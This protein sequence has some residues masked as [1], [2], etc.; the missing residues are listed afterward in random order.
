MHLVFVSSLL[1]VKNPASGFDIANRVTVD[2]LR[3]QG[4]KVSLLGYKSP[5]VAIAEADGTAVLGEQEI[6][7]SKVP[8]ATKLRWLMTAIANRTTFSSAKM[9]AC[10]RPALLDGLK[11]LKPFDGL[12]LNSVQLP[13][14]FIDDFKNYPSIFVAHNVEAQSA[15]ENAR[16]GANAFERLL[17][18]REARLLARLEGALCRQSK[19]LWTLSEDDRMALAGADKSKSAVLPLVTSMT[20]PDPLPRDRTVKYDFGLIGSW[21]WRPNRIGLEWFLTEIVPKLPRDTSIAIAG[22][23]S[24]TPAHDAHPG[25]QFLGRVPDAGE[26]LRSCAVVPLASTAGTGVQL[27]TIE[28]FES[29]IPCVATTVAVRGIDKVPSNCTVADDPKAFADALVFRLRTTKTEDGA[30]MDGRQFHT[31]QKS[32]LSA[33]IGMGVNV[34]LQKSL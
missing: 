12:V 9:L 30:A 7:T 1:P 18:R 23:L 20:P 27:K 26:F 4:I 22:D 32:M 21:S 14:A 17:F 16:H 29:G 15:A 6:T 10:G 25:L 5:G 2:A 24:G 34:V 13:G 33:A 3:E 31:S 8:A 11:S 28:T 19:F